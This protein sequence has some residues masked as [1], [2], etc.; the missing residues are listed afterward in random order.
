MNFLVEMFVVAVFVAVFLLIEGGYTLWAGF[1]NSEVRSLEKRLGQLGSGRSEATYDSLM[2]RRMYSENERFDQALRKIPRIAAI[3]Q[4]IQRSGQPMTVERFLMITAGGAFLG[5]LTGLILRMPWLGTF[6]LFAIGALVPSL[7]LSNAGRKRLKKFDEQLPDILDLMARS[8]RAGHALASAMQLVATEA[9]E[10]ISGEFRAAFEEIN[11]GIPLN[12]AMQHLADRVP[13][14]DLR[15]FIVA[16]I[17]QRETGGNL[18]EL[19]GNLANLIRERFKLFGKIRALS[20]EGRM[21][22]YV[23]AGLPFAVAFLI[24]LTNSKFLS[25]LWTDPFGHAMLGASAILM[26][27]GAIWMRNIVQIRV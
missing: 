26:I 7:L 2:K 15:F 11:Y 18:A 4:W 9:Q 1:R 25:V 21:S 16:V 17:L 14:D 22:G 5:G 10:P 23:L 8:L 27:I 3:D 6:A 13:S 12:E 19:L 24:N 20:A